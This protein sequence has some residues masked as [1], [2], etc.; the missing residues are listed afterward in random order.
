M[1]T[2]RSTWL[3]RATYA[4]GCLTL[5]MGEGDDPVAWRD[6]TYAAPS[7]LPGVLAGW[8]AQGASVGSLWSKVARF[9]RPVD[10]IDRPDGEA[11]CDLDLVPRLRAS[12]R[13]AA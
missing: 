6:Y 5:A 9:C 12:L 4:D 7:W 1:T 3:R 2:L 11:S 10:G 8:S 13:E